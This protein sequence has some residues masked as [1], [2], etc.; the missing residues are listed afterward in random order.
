MDIALIDKAQTAINSIAIASC[1]TSQ[2]RP[3]FARH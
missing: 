1:T 2:D 3:H